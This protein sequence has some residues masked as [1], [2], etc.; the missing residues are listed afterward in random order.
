MCQEYVIDFCDDT[1]GN[2]HYDMNLIKN[3]TRDNPGCLSFSHNRHVYEVATSTYT[4]TPSPDI[5]TT[6]TSS[7]AKYCPFKHYDL[8]TLRIHLDV[9]SCKMDTKGKIVNKRYLRNK[10]SE[11]IYGNE[12]IGCISLN[13]K[14]ASYTETPSPDIVTTTTSS[15]TKY[16]PFKHYDLPTLRIHV[17]S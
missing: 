15:N 10:Q 9:I 6:T 7:N 5:V 4:E 1:Y 12:E 14:K 2:L 13:D 11:Q 8:P 17:M 16:C 3:I